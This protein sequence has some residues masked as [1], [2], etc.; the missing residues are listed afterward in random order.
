MKHIEET[1]PDL[2]EAI[3]AAVIDM[4]H[5]YCREWSDAEG[6]YEFP[7][8]DL[9]YYIERKPSET[10]PGANVMVA[11]YI[12]NDNKYDFDFSDMEVEDC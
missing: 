12:H 4:L 8:V 6:P 2:A 3:K 1:Q 9:D 11:T 7:L 10:I 5:W